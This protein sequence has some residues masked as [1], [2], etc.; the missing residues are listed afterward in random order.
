VLFH[1]PLVLVVWVEM[2]VIKELQEIKGTSI[3]Y[4][5][6]EFDCQ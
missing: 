4:Y 6:V 2:M 1:H 3:A 5:S